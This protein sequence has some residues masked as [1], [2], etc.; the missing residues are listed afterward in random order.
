MN[1]A[2]RLGYVFPH[3]DG[4]AQGTVCRSSSANSVQPGQDSVSSMRSP[5][6]SA[7]SWDSPW[8]VFHKASGCNQVVWRTV[9]WS[10]SEIAGHIQDRTYDQCGDL[11]GPRIEALGVL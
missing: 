5:L 11:R 4:D 1:T 2:L 7:G 10:G 8:V 9:R 3:R 6:Q